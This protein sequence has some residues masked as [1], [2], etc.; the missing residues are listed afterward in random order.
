MGDRGVGQNVRRAL[1]NI[2][3]ASRESEPVGSETTAP[4]GLILDRRRLS[5]GA[6]PD[7][8]ATFPNAPL[9]YRAGWGY[10]LLTNFLRVI[11]G[12]WAGHWHLHAACHPGKQGGQHIGLAALHDYGKTMRTL[13]THLGPSTRL[14]KAARHRAVLSEIPLGADAEFLQHSNRRIDDHSVWGWSGTRASDL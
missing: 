6:R 12:C 14:P 9:K 4:N 11:G 8:Q 13:L 7:V 3:A 10:M 5:M 1:D 2:E